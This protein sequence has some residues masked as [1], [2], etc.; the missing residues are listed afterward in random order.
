MGAANSC[1]DD[2]DLLSNEE[3]LAPEARS[4]NPSLGEEHDFSDEL[5]KQV[6]SEGKG[7]IRVDL[8]NGQ[9]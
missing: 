7:R 6:A 2:D 4:D 5:P 9:I 1:S 8:G 3:Q